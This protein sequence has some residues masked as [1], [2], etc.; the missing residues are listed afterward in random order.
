[1]KKIVF[2]EIVKSDI[3]ACLDQLKVTKNGINVNEVEKRKKAYGDNSLP[4]GK[5]Q[6]FFVQLFKGFINPFNVILLVL[7]FISLFVD[8]IY[9][10]EKDITTFV[11]ITTMLMLSTLLRVIQDMRQSKSL[12]GLSKM[13]ENN[14]RV[15][16]E[17]K[18]TKISVSDIVLGDI[19]KISVGDIIPADIIVIEENNFYV[20]ESSLTGENQMVFKSNQLKP[21]V[22]LMEAQHICFMGSSVKKGSCLGVVVRLSKDT[23]YG[24]MNIKLN[25][26][27]AKSNFEV[28]LNK[29]SKL[30]VSFMFVMVPI[31]FIINGLTKDNWG[32]A[33][34]FAIALAVGLTPEML[35][36][37]A[38]TSLAK[39][40]VAMSKKKTIIKKI[41]VIQNLGEMD[42]LCT[43]K[44][45]TLT[46]NKMEV[47]AYLDVFGKKSEQVLMFSYLNSKYQSGYENPMDEAILEKAHFSDTFVKSD[48]IPYDFNRRMISVYGK[49]DDR[50]IMITKGAIK[51]VV[52]CCKYY[53]DGEKKIL[54]GDNF[55]NEIDKLE[56]KWH[57]NGMRSIAVAV[58][59]QEMLEK[60]LCL[61]GFITF[62]DTIKES[63]YDTIKSLKEYGVTVKILT[64]D[65][66]FSAKY[67][68][69]K[70]GLL[71]YKM[72]DGETLATWNEEELLEGVEKYHVFVK[73]NPLQ[74]EQIVKALQKKQHTVGFMGDGIND[75]L[76]LKASDVAISVVEAQDIAKEVAEVVLL[77]S[78]LRVL[79]DGIIEGRK[80]YVN[81]M[82]YIKM[83]ASSN[84]GN[85]LS[86]V[87]ASAFLP[88]LPMMSLQ[89]LILNLTYDISSM[90]LPWDNVDDKYIKK[91]KKWDATDLRRFM[92]W[93]GPCSSIF[94]IVTFIILYFI[95]CPSVA[96]KFY[97][98]NCDQ[99]L[100]IAT[101][102]AGWFIESMWTQTSIIHIIRTEKIP[103]I[104]SIASR[105]LIILSLFG[106]I[107][108]TIFPYTS[109]GSHLGLASLPYIFFIYLIVILVMYLMVISL[110][111]YWYVGKYDTL[112]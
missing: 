69:E 39:G 109:L 45:G 83:T 76:A 6:H 106:I 101:F 23:M 53:F 44:T 50:F 96:S 3:Q 41:D 97:L 37:I 73:L 63:T 75:V 36:M 42:V 49:L 24:Q 87:I 27:Q 72:V 25:E 40:C 90:A 21:F 18:E 54:I 56:K 112:L 20:D 32:Q 31:V 111:K 94:D 93:M 107:I 28:G 15:I 46:E 60:D 79:E 98:P 29:V 7:A 43:D 78:D 77:E 2:D 100:F 11:I 48:E 61:Y 62:S 85:I 35:P 16:R 55:L 10:E 103:F 64:G 30:L 26:N 67:L 9:S 89:L 80:T 4:K 110:I 86:I 81:M 38:T 51:E 47:T 102:H 14:I 88:F 13:I 74:K 68:C 34:L 104:G 17:G 92:L 33:F 105:P 22:S 84:F 52:E 95:I 8:V 19:V 5:K 66:L 59:E 70:I 12:E 1:M 108:L 65:T 99:V 82:K 91:P 57:Q 58:R 71:N